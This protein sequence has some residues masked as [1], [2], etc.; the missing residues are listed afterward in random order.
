MRLKVRWLRA[1]RV[2]QTAITSSTTGAR[3]EPKEVENVIYALPGV[4]D[5]AVV[6]QTDAVLGQAIRAFLVLVEGTSYT[7]RQVIE[8]CA[9]KLEPFMVPKYVT[10]VSSIPKTPSGKITKKNIWD[11]SVGAR[12]GGDEL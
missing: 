7:T 4:Q 10:F 8:H 12:V 6:G 9:A 2:T 5:A 1:R 3:S 11:H